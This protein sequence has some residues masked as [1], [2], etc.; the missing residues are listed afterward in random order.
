M[1]WTT[2][3]SPKHRCLWITGRPGSGK[4]T[5]AATVA[6]RL[7][8][9]KALAAQF[10]VNRT[11]SGTTNPNSIFPSLAI[12]LAEY[13][14]AA[15][16]IIHNVLQEEPG[17]ADKINLRQADRL[18]LEPLRSLRQ[19]SVVVIIDALD[20]L[21]DLSDV[22]K[23]FADIAVELP[24]NVKIV[25]TSR[26]ERNVTINFPRDSFHID[27]LTQDSRSDVERFLK[28]RLESLAESL[29]W[30]GWPSPTQFCT[31]SQHADGLFHWAATACKW[32]YCCVES[33]GTAIKDTVLDEVASLGM[34]DLDDL[35]MAILRRVLGTNR[36]YIQY[37]HQVVG[38]LIVLREPL[39]IGSLR[40]L[41]GI[42]ASKFDVK[43]FFERMRSIL[44]SGTGRIN[45][46]TVPQMHKTFFDFVTSCRANPYQIDRQF[47]HALVAA[48][49]FRIM[50]TEL[51]FNIFDFPSSYF[52]NSDLKPV[53]KLKHYLPRHLRYC[54]LS[55]EN[56]I[57]QASLVSLTSR[58]K[59]AL[60]NEARRFMLDSLLYWL[61]VLSIA[62]IVRQC[63]HRALGCLA[64]WIRLLVRSHPFPCTLC[65]VFPSGQ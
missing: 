58:D 40:E 25:I 46:N 10:F 41:L 32:V 6:H 44:I 24:S 42:P 51:R 56:H 55:W 61:E 50:A 39:N 12:Q 7:K 57:E 49:A 37:Y 52:K 14:S 33:E 26:A 28:M 9:K 60:V 8:N 59:E 53:R 20:E 18:L 34:G 15:A 23:I 36:C 19:Q 31:L 35:Y 30:D 65:S 64:S 22:P 3:R 16:A 54:C 47:H 5:I 63:A 62:G 1:S 38:C 17:I 13:D 48:S 11:V 27:L 4:T 43:N 29:A 45:D 21:N 2:I